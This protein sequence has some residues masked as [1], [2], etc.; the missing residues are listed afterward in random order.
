MSIGAGARVEEAIVLDRAE[1]KVT[2]K[3]LE[4]NYCSLSRNTAVCCTVE[5]M[6]ISRILF[7][8]LFDKSLKA[9]DVSSSIALKKRYP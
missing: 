7:E 9:F 6:D 2:S 3:S 5:H 1:I 8:D 4:H